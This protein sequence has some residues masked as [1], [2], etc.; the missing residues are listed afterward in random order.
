MKPSLKKVIGSVLF[1]ALM[2]AVSCNSDETT[3]INSQQINPKEW[4]NTTFKNSAEWNQNID[5]GTQTMYWDDLKYQKNGDFDIFE[6]PL[7]EKNNSINIIAN[8]SR[9]ESET[10]RTLKGTITRLVILKDEK[11]EMIVRKFY[12]VPDYEYLS[13]KGYDVSDVVYGKEGDD[14]TGLLITKN[15]NNEI[16]AYHKIVD[17]KIEFALKEGSNTDNSDAI[18]LLSYKGR[19]Q[20]TSKSEWS[21]GSD[22]GLIIYSGGSNTSNP[23]YPVVDIPVSGSG[24]SSPYSTGGTSGSG[25]TAGYD[26][27]TYTAQS[28]A[29]SIDPSKL[30]PCSQEI[31]KKLR[32]LTKNDIASMIKA[33]DNPKSEFKIEMEVGKIENANI[34]GQTRPS[35][36][37]PSAIKIIINEDYIKGANN[38][39]KSPTDLSVAATVAHEI[40]HAYII[41]QMPNY[42]LSIGQDFDEVYNAYVAY[43]K[44]KNPN[45]SPEAHHKL[46]AEKYVSVLAATLQEFHTGYPVGIA[47]AG[48]MYRDLAWAGLYD[49]ELFKTQYPN[50]HKDKNYLERQRIIDRFRAERDDTNFG[51]VKPAGKPCKK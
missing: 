20:N 40:I 29:K 25:G 38:F 43:T 1:I 24:G 4:F 37:S 48:E 3:D 11:D 34:Y 33:F 2:I 17:G 36:I 18:E 6:Y 28:I 27:A 51:D 19:I 41:S 14:F 50:D 12:Y 22:G 7:V 5:S 30:D 49:T 31:L 21:T 15:W 45:I 10:M 13:S 26:A 47:F 9:N 32:G 35:N 44:Y 42:Q 16:L 8:K 46:I 39:G 23:F